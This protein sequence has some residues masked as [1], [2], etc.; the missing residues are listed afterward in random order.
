MAKFPTALRIFLKNSLLGVIFL[1]FLSLIFAIAGII[2]IQGVANLQAIGEAISEGN[3][4]IILFAA[5]TLFAV[6]IIGLV[7]FAVSSRVGGI[8]GLKDK[9]TH[10]PT[11]IKIVSVLILG[12]LIVVIL[13]AFEVFLT[14][15]DENF[16]G[17]TIQGL[18]NSF[19]S[20][21]A[22]SFFGNLIVIAILGTIVLAAASYFGKIESKAGEKGINIR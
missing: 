14:G 5:F 18:V 3:I 9:P 16:G 13:G 22:I 20:G 4:A 17:F 1:I 7:V 8:F 10:M 12:L 21:N 11:K 2:G 6:G 19:Q 15:L